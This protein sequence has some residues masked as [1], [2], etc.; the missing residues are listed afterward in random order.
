MNSVA[1]VP[2]LS[3]PASN[4]GWGDAAVE[5]N[6]RVIKGTLLK[7]GDGRWTKGK[8]GTPVED[9]T[10][11]VALSTTAAWVNWKGG[12]PVEYRMR[13]PGRR[14][15]DRE[16]LR[17]LDEA[18]WEAGPDGEPRDP[19]QSTRFV[20]LV[21]P[22]TAEP[23]TFSTSSFGGRA[24]V[25]D[26]ADQIQRMRYARPD[27]VPVVELHTAPMLTRFGRKSKPWFKVV[28]WRCGG[29]H[30]GN[31]TPLPSS[32]GT[33]PQLEHASNAALETAQALDDDIPF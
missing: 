3:A 1:K 17:D 26:L 13:E 18:D 5:A 22:M 15:P 31:G 24:A 33:A 16:E 29:S 6:E 28:D 30:D 7:H 23:F 27:A 4:D 20:H 9:R 14:L 8:E 19:W 10:R 21:D 32:S 12:K 25:S 2:T 11:L